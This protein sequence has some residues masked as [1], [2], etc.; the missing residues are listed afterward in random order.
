M[1]KTKAKCPKCGQIATD[2]YS[3]GLELQCNCGW[4][5]VNE[6]FVGTDRDYEHVRERIAKAQAEYVPLEDRPP[7]VSFLEQ[8]LAPGDFITYVTGGTSA[9][10]VL[11]RIKRIE[12]YTR[13]HDGHRGESNWR[14]VVNRFQEGTRTVENTKDRTYWKIDPKK[15][16]RVDQLHRVVKIDP[17]EW[18]DGLEE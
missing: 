14:L 5:W 16:V 9:R 10:L 15:E 12:P 18:A 7:P 2:T 11:A 3:W 4:R 8:E 1:P 6:A 17:P 13:G